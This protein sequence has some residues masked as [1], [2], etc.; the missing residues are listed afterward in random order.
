MQYKDQGEA[1][2]VMNAPQVYEEEVITHFKGEVDRE[3][4]RDSYPLVQVFG[5]SND[6]LQTSARLGVAVLADDGLLWLCYPK[7]T[8]KAYKGSDCSRE[9]VA[10]L[11]ADEGFEPVRQIAID[12]DWSALRFRHVDRIKN[13]VRTS[14]VTDKGKQRIQENHT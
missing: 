11:L 8:S 3:A 5:I 10:V 9:T 6:S 14:A 12:E 7:K 2:L 1:V 13:M 4:L